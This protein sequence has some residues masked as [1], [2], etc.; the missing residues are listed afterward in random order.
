MKKVLL[1]LLI[2]MVYSCTVTNKVVIKDYGKQMELVKSHF[3][4]IYEN[5]KNGRVNIDGVYTYTHK[6]TGAEK[7]HVSYHY[8]P[9]RY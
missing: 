7:V 4:E 8:V 1:I 5:Y 6:K 3:P 9:Y 2:G